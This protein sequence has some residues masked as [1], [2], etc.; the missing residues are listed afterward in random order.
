MGL[1]ICLI[2]LWS[3]THSGINQKFLELERN[4]TSDFLKVELANKQLQLIIVLI[5]GVNENIIL[6]LP[7]SSREQYQ[8]IIE[9]YP[10]VKELRDRL[11]LELDY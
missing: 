6:D 7:L 9:Q 3:L 10:L 4:K 8:K 1:K 2:V 11:R 5:E